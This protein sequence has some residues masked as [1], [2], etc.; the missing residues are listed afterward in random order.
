MTPE[1]LSELSRYPAFPKNAVDLIRVAGL[2]GAAALIRA[3]PGQEWPCP[4]RVGG[5]NDKGARRY[6]QLLEIVGETAARRIVQWCG[7]GMLIVPNMK[8][9]MRQRAQA[10]IRS[11][12]DELIRH[13]YSSPEAVFGLGIKYNINGR[14]VEK[15]I[16]QPDAELSQ[17]IGQG[18]L[19]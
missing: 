12:Y 13:G 4:V 15:I 17:P 11:E 7:G 18:C 19:F 6:E 10:L 9:A 3:W 1:L 14:S 8:V 5:S 2:D 16:R